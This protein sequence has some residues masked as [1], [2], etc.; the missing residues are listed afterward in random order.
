MSRL[1]VRSR[2]AASVLGLA[3]LLGISGCASGSGGG[4][5]GGAASMITE[6]QIDESGAETVYEVVQRYHSRWLRPA[7]SFGASSV[8]S[9][10]GM[11][12]KPGDAVADEVYPKVVLDGAPYGEVDALKSISARTVASIRFISATDATTR[13]GTGYTGG[14]IEVQSRSGR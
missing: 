1:G 9:R 13:Y 7:R 3:G 5:A 4:S 14:V 10:P 6:Q 2:R 11:P 8:T 12:Q